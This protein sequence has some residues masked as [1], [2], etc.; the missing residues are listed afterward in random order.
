MK[1]KAWLQNSYVEH[2]DRVLCLAFDRVELCLAFDRVELCLAFDRVE[3]CLA[4]DRVVGSNVK[5]DASSALPVSRNGSMT[6]TERMLK[7]QI[8]F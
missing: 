6:S 3:L 7:T 1:V 4:F 2:V 5:L 8:V